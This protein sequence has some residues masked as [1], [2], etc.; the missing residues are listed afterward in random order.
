MKQQQ[1][2]LSSLRHS[3]P[4]PKTRRLPAICVLLLAA[5]TAAAQPGARPPLGDGPWEF[6]TY[7]AR[8]TPIR[9]AIVAR[10]LTNPWSMA[11]LPNGDLL[12]TERG[13]T[14][15]RLSD[16]ELSAP[17]GGLEDLPIDKL[18]DIALH[19]GF[20]TNRLVYL[21]YIKREPH[22]DGSDTYWA[23]TALVRGRLDGNA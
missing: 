7:E 1:S 10:G 18:F 23:T 6:T 4:T 19:P 8:G 21:T 12:I 17:L 20:E 16:G 9:V 5:A 3:T 13:G 14:L 2:K 15:R 11:W 22:P